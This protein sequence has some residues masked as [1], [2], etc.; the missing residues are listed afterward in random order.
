MSLPEHNYFWKCSQFVEFSLIQFAINWARVSLLEA[1]VE[2]VSSLDSAFKGSEA[3]FAIHQLLAGLRGLSELSTGTHLLCLPGEWKF[4]EALCLLQ[5]PL[6]GHPR[7]ERWPWVSCS[8]TH[9]LPVYFSP[10]LLLLLTWVNPLINYLPLGSNAPSTL[11]PEFASEPCC[12]SL[13]RDCMKTTLWG[14]GPTASH[15]IK[16]RES[17]SKEAAP[18]VT[19]LRM[20]PLVCWN[21]SLS[22]Q[23]ENE[24]GKNSYL[25]KS[26]LC[27]ER[28]FVCFS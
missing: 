16:N 13:P 28:G 19:F 17:L 11:V 2:T 27:Q 10:S 26:L 4:Q 9:P 20:L 6:Q 1:I 24:A 14:P 18:W 25:W 22:I 3:S 5:S 7:Q 15:R 21:L 23:W 8:N 12:A